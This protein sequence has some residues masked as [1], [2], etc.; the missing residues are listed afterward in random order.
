MTDTEA[1]SKPTRA[2][3][4]PQKIRPAAATVL[5]YRHVKSARVRVAPGQ[6]GR[7]SFALAAKTKE[8][9]EARTAL[10]AEWS[11]RMQGLAPVESI[12][13]ILRDGGRAR[14]EKR[15]AEVREAV[16]VVAAGL[17]TKK[18]SVLAPSFEDFAAD[19]TGGK[20]QRAH[21]DHVRDKEHARDI[22]ILRD[23]VN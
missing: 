5:R 19:W 14:T 16:E 20:L 1:A 11:E 21:P 18:T 22:Q 10:L 3:R 6:N 23:Y 4:T 13:S 2:P 12:V 7:R 17:A 9:V 15:L 8:E